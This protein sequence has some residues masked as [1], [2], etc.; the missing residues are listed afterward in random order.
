MKKSNTFGIFI[1]IEY[2][3]E[4]QA[5][6]KILVAFVVIALRIISL[7]INTCKV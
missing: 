7:K 5:S 6:F 3:L 2:G 1:F 4:V